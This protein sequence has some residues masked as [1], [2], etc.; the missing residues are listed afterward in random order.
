MFPT[1]EDDR[2]AAQP[3]LFR[4]CQVAGFDGLQ[5]RAL[6]MADGAQ[7]QVDHLHLLA[8]VGVAVGRFVLAVKGFDDVTA[9]RNH[10]FEGLAAVA[11]VEVAAVVDVIGGDA[12]LFEIGASLLLHR[13]EHLLQTLRIEGFG[14]KHDGARIVL[15]DI[16]HE[17]AGCGQDAG[18]ARHHYAGDLQQPG[19]KGCV[20]TAGATEGEEGEFAWVEAPLD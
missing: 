14:G 2:M 6:R 4:W 15:D 11:H 8:A 12:F 3:G 17:H 19:E 10:Q 1:V 18:V 7:T 9:G 13:R 16:G 5:G 20:H